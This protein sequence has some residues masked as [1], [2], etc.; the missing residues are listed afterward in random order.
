MSGK[1]FISSQRPDSNSLALCRI[2]L[3]E[4]ALCYNRANTN[5]YVSGAGME[6]KLCRQFHTG[7]T[8]EQ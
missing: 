5:T 3:T 1:L 4:N 7:E 2:V 6:Y 8:P